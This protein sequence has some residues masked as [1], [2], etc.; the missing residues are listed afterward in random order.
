L[1]AVSLPLAMR[2]DPR[3]AR[4]LLALILVVAAVTL[5]AIFQG[6]WTLPHDEEYPLFR[7]LNGLRT[8]VDQ[9]RTVLE[10]IRAAIAALVAGFDALIAGLGWPGVLTVAGGLGLIFGGFR[11]ATLAVVGFAALGVLGLWD[12]SMATLSLVLAALVLSLLIGI[13]V[14]IFIGRSDRASALITPILDV[15]Q[16]MPTFAYL[17]PMTL[18]FLTGAPSS[19]IATLIYAIPPAIRITSLGIRGVARETV[20][21]AVSLGSTRWQVLAKV[22]LPLARRTIGIGINQT[23]MMALSMVVITGLI[24]APG[25]GRNILQALSK[26]DV[27]GAFDAGLAIVI[28][29][30]V[31]D[32]LTDRAGEWMDPRFR[33][34][35]ETQR[36]RRTLHVATL[37]A[38]A[39]AILLARLLPDATKFPRTL[40][41]SFRE[42]V[43]TL[44]GWITDTFSGLTLT[45][46]GAFTD[47]VL[48]PLEWVLTTAPWWLI[49]A[50]IVLVAWYISG[51]RAS[52][53]AA[54]CLGVIILLGLWNHSMTTLAMVLVATFFTLAIGLVLGILTARSDRVRTAIRPFLDMAQTMPA[55]VYL[56]PAIALFDPSRFT[57]IVAA[58]IYAVP[59][60][61]RLVDAGI[62]GVSTTAMEAAT[63]SG[64]TERQLLWYVQL[65]LSRRALLVASNQGIVLVLAMVVIGGL[66]GAGGLGYDV[67]AGFSQGEDFGK[68]L[69]AGT[70]IVLLG[71]MLDRITQGAGGRR[72]TVVAE[73]G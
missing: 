36:R 52:V 7:S 1:T 12:A 59:P 14:G 25:L 35:D 64:S 33:R 2:I 37:A 30:I 48:N 19:T 42:P 69:A 27:G 17:T 71:I 21:S 4:R 13:P 62:R 31:L 8:F 53:T 16:I 51:R 58:I 10:P 22:Q 73:A 6:Q 61:I 34:S 55:F 49:V 3:S 47:F 66:V 41:F 60:V 68:G 26:V 70:A 50:G 28:L 23:I 24:G 56:I 11:L 72:S 46:K 5:Y 9:H 43:N 32:R 63:A 39:A 38:V 15:M 18:L 20:E 57:A 54:F 29:A 65:P 44:V 45:F 40:A 67:V